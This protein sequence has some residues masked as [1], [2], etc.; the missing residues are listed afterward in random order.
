MDIKKQSEK[1]NSQL[2]Y[3][4]I[5][6]YKLAKENYC[7]INLYLTKENTAKTSFIR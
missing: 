1:L 4:K 6:Y 7:F 3:L 5:I 2:K